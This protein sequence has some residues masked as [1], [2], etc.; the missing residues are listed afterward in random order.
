MDILIEQAVV[1]DVPALLDLQRKAFWPEC[2]KLGWEDAEPMTESVEQAR[3]EFVQCTTLKARDGNGRIIGSVRGNVENGSLYIG[4]LMVLPEYQQRGIGKQLL[5]EIQSRMPHDH[6]WL[7]VCE[8]VK[9]VYDFYLREGF[10]PFKFEDAG[11]GL[12]W[13][14]MEKKAPSPSRINSAPKC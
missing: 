1:Q 10:E 8:Q 11:R 12:T 9:H 4:R 7:C 6:V 13:I 2:R 3:E 5:C 14:Y